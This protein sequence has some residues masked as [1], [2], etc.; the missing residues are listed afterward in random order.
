MTGLKQSI[1]VSLG[2][3]GFSCF[4]AFG[5]GLA[6]QSQSSLHWRMEAA[7]KMFYPGE[8]IGLTI[9]VTN[10]GRQE[11][12]LDFGGDGIEA[13]S[14]EIRDQKD[15]VLAKRGHIQ[16]LGV[17]RIGRMTIPP[18]EERQ[19]TIIVNQWCPTILPPGEYGIVCQIDRLG[20]PPQR[21]GA[22]VL[23]QDGQYEPIMRLSLD[24]TIVKSDPARFG[25]ILAKLAE[26]A[27]SKKVRTRQELIDRQFAR[28]LLV[29]T[30]SD[31]A[32]THQVQIL[33]T[34]AST[35]LKLDAINSLVRSATPEAAIGLTEIIQ[36]A[37]EAKAGDTEKRKYEDIRRDAIEGVY[38]L[39]DLNRPD[40]LAVTEKVTAKHPRATQ[41]KPLD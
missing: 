27:L 34:G 38:K 26:V 15:L 40:I 4:V 6:D 25:E 1:L 24:V 13:V 32:V 28:E 18:G 12:V 16:R 21:D 37:D 23:A 9:R 8:A 31:L 22:E 30:Q 3:L 39:R 35:W 33:K 41:A 17:G 14:M 11:E 36:E 10:T 2:L 19:K 20:R 5:D 7:K 29:F